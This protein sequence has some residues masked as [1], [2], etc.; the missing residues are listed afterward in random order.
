MLAAAALAV[1]AVTSGSLAQAESLGGHHKSGLHNKAVLHGVDKKHSNK[2][3]ARI[4]RSLKH[5]E[6]TGNFRKETLDQM[7]RKMASQKVDKAILKKRKKA[8]QIRRQYKKDMAAL[9][10]E[11][12]KLRQR[13]KKQMQ[14][15]QDGNSQAIRP[16]KPAVRGGRDNSQRLGGG[17]ASLQPKV[18]L[19]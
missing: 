18:H 12:R 7:R 16:A 10:K 13:Y 17:G 15:L 11:Q 4:E 3:Q 14:A 8:A 9:E 6:E 5:L 2:K 1:L 19:K